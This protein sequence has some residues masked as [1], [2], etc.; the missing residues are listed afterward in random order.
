MKRIVILCMILFITMLP[1]VNAEVTKGSDYFTNGVSVSS[2]FQ[3]SKE[4][5]THQIYFNKI[6]SGNNSDY[7]IMIKKSNSKAGLLKDSAIEIKIDDFPVIE[8]NQYKYDKI[9]ASDNQYLFNVTIT[10]KVPPEVIN[11]IKD[12][13]RIAIRSA[14]IDGIPRIDVIPAEVLDE[15][16]EVINTTE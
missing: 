16:K 15:W 14:C 1:V 3:S 8:L 11:Q 12:A 13:K 4:L 2:R 5:I 7:K 6:I 9:V 10:A